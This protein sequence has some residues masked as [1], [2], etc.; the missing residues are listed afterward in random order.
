M[1]VAYTLVCRLS[2]SVLGPASFPLLAFCGSNEQPV[3]EHFSEYSSL[4]LSRSKS[5]GHEL[6][7]QLFNMLCLLPFKQFLFCFLAQKCLQRWERVHTV[8]RCSASVS[9][10]FLFAATLKLYASSLKK[11]ASTPLVIF[12]LILQKWKCVSNREQ[13]LWGH[14]CHSG[15]CRRGH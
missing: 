14:L 8:R 12:S 6:V 1:C 3:L 15:V 7:E 4:D 5:W 9:I 11:C 10:C 2:T 13:H